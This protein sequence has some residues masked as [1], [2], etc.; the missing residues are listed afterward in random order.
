KALGATVVDGACH[1]TI[2]NG[3]LTLDAWVEAEKLKIGVRGH[4][5]TGASVA[6]TPIGTELA[7]RTWGFAFWGR[8]TMFGEAPVVGSPEPGQ[9]DFDPAQ[10]V[11]IRILTLLDEVGVG[12]R[13]DADA[14][15][16]VAV[17]RTVFSNPE[18]V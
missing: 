5:A 4:P 13:K 8:G 16:F 7:R 11:S 2:P 6:M 12:I 14:L 9:S 1:V 10:A 3:N 17:V 15:R 18:H